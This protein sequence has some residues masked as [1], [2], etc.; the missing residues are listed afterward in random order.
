MQRHYDSE[1]QKEANADAQSRTTPPLSRTDSIVAASFRKS[2]DRAFRSSTLAAPDS[3][4]TAADKDFA[5]IFGDG[6][7]LAAG[8]GFEPSGF[9]EAWRNNLDRRNLPTAQAGNWGH[10][11]GFAVHLYNKDNV[12]G[13][14]V[15]IYVPPGFDAH[16]PVPGA[17]D[18]SVSFHYPKLNGV[19]DVLLVVFH[20]QNYDV[21]P[22]VKNAAGNILIGQSGGLGGDNP[23]YTHSCVQAFHG[24]YLKPSNERDSFRISVRQLFLGHP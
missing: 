23:M 22:R 17:S 1:F 19:K 21:Q 18:N 3:V 14:W 7:T 6:Y 13:W 2:M 10:L 24:R 4:P 12:G 15:N 11:E 20:V 8:S 16:S 5:N 9:T